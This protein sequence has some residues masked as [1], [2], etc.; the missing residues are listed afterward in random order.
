MVGIKVYLNNYILPKTTKS[1]QKATISLTDMGLTTQTIS[2]LR[3]QY[4]NKVGP[5]S[6]VFYMD[7]IHIEERGILEPVYYLNPP[8]LKWFFVTE[9]IF[10]VADVYNS[11]MASGTSPN[12]DYTKILAQVITDGLIFN[13]VTSSILQSTIT[14]KTLLDFMLYGGSIDV[15]GYNGTETWLK[16]KITFPTPILL[17]SENSDYMSLS[18]TED[19][20]GLTKFTCLARGYTI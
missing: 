9:L 19:L 10:F 13:I 4:E 11:T 18:I 12:L 20:S 2:S 17:K 15:I 6:P 16:L 3:V 1:W 8:T 14:F 5:N 7:A